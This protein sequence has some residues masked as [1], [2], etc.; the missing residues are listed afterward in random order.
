MLELS[1]S[2]NDLP[3]PTSQE[4]EEWS[5]IEELQKTCPHSHLMRD[6]DLEDGC[7]HCGYYSK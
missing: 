1:T 3:E 2:T 7:L 4:L 5:Y 6:L